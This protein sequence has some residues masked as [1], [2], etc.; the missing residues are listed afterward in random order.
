MRIRRTS[1][2]QSR[3]T[4]IAAPTVVY[5]GYSIVCYVIVYNIIYPHTPALYNNNK[6]KV[7][8]IE[9]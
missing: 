4:N 6:V 9:R 5:G 3:A 8:A 2:T 7:V 1:A